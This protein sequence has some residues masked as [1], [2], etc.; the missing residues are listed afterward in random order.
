MVANI[1]EIET[2][3]LKRQIAELSLYEFTKQAW[4]IIEGPSSPFVDGW[5]IQAL[6]EHL[7]ACFR[8]Q[9]K[10]LRVNM[11]PRHMKS[12]LVGVLFPAWVFIQ[13]PD[14]QF[15]F[16]SYSQTLSVR[17]SVRCRRLIESNWY[18]TRWGDRYHLLGDQNTKLR[19]DNNQ[20][21]YRI[22]SS[23]GG[24][25]VGD[26]GSIIVCD[27][28]NNAAE[29]ESEKK[30]EGTND[31]FSS[32]FATRLNNPR[33]G[34]IIVVQ[35][36]IHQ[37][38]LSGYLKEIDTDKEWTEVVFPM[39]YMAGKKCKTI[40]LATTKGKVWEDPRTKEG[41]IL[42]PKMYGAKEVKSLK[43][44]LGSEYRITAQLQQDPSSTVGSIF[45]RS[46]FCLWK[47][48]K[49]ITIDYTIQS[50]DTGFTDD[51][52][53]SNYSACTTWGVFKNEHGV[54]NVILLGLWRDKVQYHELRNITLCL[55]QDYTWNPNKPKPT[56]AKKQPDVVLV[57]AKGSGLIL[58]QDLRR[59]GVPAFRFDPKTDKLN[60]ARMVSAYVECGRVWVPTKVKN[61]TQ[62]MSYADTLVECCSNFPGNEDTYDVVDTMTQALL[63]LIQSGW[64]HH[65]E[66]DVTYDAPARPPR[67]SDFK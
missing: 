14:E 15:L 5:H 26:G 53:V 36:R 16:A 34:V 32:S 56:K 51:P 43:N 57:E 6:C 23:V 3:F 54:P 18:Q 46:W 2:E 63:R 19:F 47:H 40:V 29:G 37:R 55:Y 10:R 64:I 24:T 21:G 33:E 1:E 49:P 8:R 44:A 20:H 62:L 35:Q 50:W 41:E 59:A 39:E 61:G 11:P 66:D 22:A 17:D 25:V 7:E 48:D 31:W 65:A 67:K 4:P 13:K 52:E 27:D 38:D 60:R 12:W 9:I 58:F 28:P 42:W 30:R 45:K